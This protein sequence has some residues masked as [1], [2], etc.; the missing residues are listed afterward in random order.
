VNVVDD[1]FRKTG[2]SG[3]RDLLS[4]PSSLM[5]GFLQPEGVA[6]LLREHEVGQ[7]DNHKLLFSLVVFEQWLRQQDVPASAA[8]PVPR[9]LGSH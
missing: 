1:W 5:Y 3:I 2:D 7:N 6:R 8:G 4:D 9:A